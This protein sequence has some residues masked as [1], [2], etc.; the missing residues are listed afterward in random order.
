MPLIPENE[1]IRVKFNFFTPRAKSL[2]LH[3]KNAKIKSVFFSFLKTIVFEVMKAIRYL[4]ES[5]NLL[6]YSS[7]NANEKCHY[8]GNFIRQ[9]GI[10][11]N[12]S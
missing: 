7:K 6:T 10:S 8:P 12:D 4:L 2:I 3:N 1:Q 9:K 11:K 5:E